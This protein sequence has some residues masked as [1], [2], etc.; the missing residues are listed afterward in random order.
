MVFIPSS[1]GQGILRKDSKGNRIWI[2]LALWVVLF[3]FL[4]PDHLLPGV[5]SGVAEDPM[6]QRE[7]KLRTLRKERDRFFKEN[8]HTPLKGSDRKRFKGLFYYPVVAL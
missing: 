8:D 2:F 4:N 6:G 5:L 1:S 7:E 3:F